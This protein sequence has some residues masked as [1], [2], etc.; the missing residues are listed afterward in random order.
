MT[1]SFA[2]SL[3]LLPV[4]LAAA[5]SSAAGPAMAD[6][7]SDGRPPALSEDHRGDFS[8]L[9]IA[10]TNPDKLMADWAQPTPGVNLAVESAMKR[11]QPI[12]TFLVFKGCK[13][14]AA[15]ACNVTAQI[16]AIAPD[17]KSYAPPQDMPVWVDKAPPPNLNLQMS[18]GGFGLRIEN[19]DP[20]GAYVVKATITDHVANVTLHTQETLTANDK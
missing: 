18:E 16:E 8:V 2:C 7:S 9:Q 5:L 4:A 15:G 20:L 12:V 3:R 6:P 17:G 13:V 1:W 11:N 14:D 19:Q 10:T